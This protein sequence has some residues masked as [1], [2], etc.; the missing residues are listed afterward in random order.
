L[1]I[2]Y[3]HFLKDSEIFMQLRILRTIT[4]TNTY[5]EK[6]QFF[7]KHHEWE[8]VPIVIERSNKDYKIINFEE[9]CCIDII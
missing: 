5:E 7:N 9:P 8:D 6:L 1:Y 4:K 3:L 2:L